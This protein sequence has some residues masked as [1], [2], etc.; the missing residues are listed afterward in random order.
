MQRSHFQKQLT[1][2]GT[3]TNKELTPGLSDLWWRKFGALPDDVLAAAFEVVIDTCRFFPSP[4]EFNDI[5]RQVAASRGAIVDGATAW[6]ECERLIFRQWS[7]AGD[8][9][10]LQSGQGYPWP[11]PR[12]K[13]IVRERLNLTVR[14]IAMMHARDYDQTR[15][16][17]IAAYDSGQAVERAEATALDAGNVRRLPQGAD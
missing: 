11:N 17:F 6:D 12:C 16:R 15:A 3:A 13:D 8:R 7:E 1:L 5:L 14:G 9:L 4:A 10:V 2:I